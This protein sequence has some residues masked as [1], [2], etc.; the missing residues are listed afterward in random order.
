MRIS[1]LDIQKQQFR[2][3]F[4]GFDIREVD[5]FLETVA[6]EF[7]GL[8]AENDAL[9]E[10]VARLEEQVSDYKSRE[11]SLQETLIAAKEMSEQLKEGAQK[12]GELIVA[13]AEARAER[14]LAEAH[15]RLA[16][17]HN[18]IDELKRQY[19]QFE[20][21]VRSAVEAHLKLLEMSREEPGARE[22]EQ[23]LLKGSPHQA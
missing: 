3:R 20:V 15:Q 17:L 16:R 6:E 7:K 1:P 10:E 11:R 9:K 8:V 2:L 22:E 23:D 14:T 13:E 5:A 4:R 19:L 21:K 12:K 18:D